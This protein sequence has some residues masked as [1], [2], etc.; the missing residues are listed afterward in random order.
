[1]DTYIQGQTVMDGRRL[2]EAYL[3]ALLRS[4]ID[5]ARAVLDRALGAGLPPQ[6]LYMGVLQPALYE[7]GERWSRAEI[8]IAQ[9]HLVTAATQALMA[10]MADRLGGG[11]R[12]K[13]TV[14]VACAEQEMHA[15]GA[16]MVADF[17]HADGWDVI[18][19]G[20]L[21]PPVE[22]AALA[23]ERQVVAVALSAALPERIPLL[24]RACAA[25]SVLDPRPLVLAGGQ[26][27]AGSAERALA[28][29][30]DAYARDAAEAVAVLDQRL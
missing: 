9:E 26:A 24:A 28:T 15:V 2:L 5:T 14:L 11:R 18:F 17:L 19:L 27:F 1:M 20:A 10:Q 22:L 13:A 12:R 8:S 30:A 7:V 6:D 21:T 29:G 3:D 25:L 4:D 16:R 23:R